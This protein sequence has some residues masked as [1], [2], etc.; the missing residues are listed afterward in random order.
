MPELRRI[1]CPVDFSEFSVGAYRYALSLAR[2]YHAKL[3]VQH[4]V[5]LGRHPSAYY[6]PSAGSFEAFGRELSEKG[7]EQLRE[8]VKRYTPNGIQPECVVQQGEAPDAILSFAEARKAD[9]I[10]M[11]TH[12]RRGFDRLMLGSATERVIRK[13]PCPVLVVRKPADD[14]LDSGT[15]RDSVPLARILFCTDFSEYS[16]RALE[17]AVSLAERYS[18]ELM[19]LHVLE[20]VPSPSETAGALATATERLGKLIPPERG[21]TV[22]MKTEVRIGKP[23]QQIIQFVKETQTDLVVMAVHG[24]GVLDLAVFGSTTYRVIQLGPCPVLAVH[25]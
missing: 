24:R 12:G 17:P 11:G 16:Q 25:V 13:A 4:I 10:V 14:F 6:A 1:V 5:E 2:H 8:F 22:R 21:K 18:A 7:K 9:L 19:L 3:F 20:D 23:Y 15:P